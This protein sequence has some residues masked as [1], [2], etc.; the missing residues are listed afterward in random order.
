MCGSARHMGC[1]QACDVP[2]GCL[3]LCPACDKPLEVLVMQLNAIVKPVF[4]PA[5]HCGDCGCGHVQHASCINTKSSE[6]VDAS[7]VDVALPPHQDC[8]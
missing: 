4:S 5:T 3:L 7:L 2:H 8:R 1:M 6:V